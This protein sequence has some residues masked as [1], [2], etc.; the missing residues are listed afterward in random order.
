VC[1][2]QEAA[3]IAGSITKHSPDK[4]AELAHAAADSSRTAL[5]YLGAL[6]ATIPGI[7]DTPPVKSD[8][9][10][11]LL[12]TPATRRLVAV[13]ELA[14]QAGAAVDKERGWIDG[15][16]DPVGYGETFAGMLTALRVEVSGPRGR[17]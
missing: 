6:G 15:D 7:E 1:R 5:D 3:S 17:E 9:P 2:A 14:A 16:G 11:H 12:D 4:A 13:L 10:L 8:V